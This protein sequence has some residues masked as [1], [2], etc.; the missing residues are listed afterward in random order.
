[1]STA[2]R[3][4]IIMV[5]VLA[6]A[7]L[8]LI[9]YSMNLPKAQVPVQI[10]ESTPAPAPA[11]VGYFVAAHPLPRGT[12]ARDEDFTTRSAS[13]SDGVPAGAILDTPDARIGLRGSLVRNFLDT[14]SPVTSRDILRPRERG[15]LASVLAP[16][17]RAISI[18]VDAASGV[19]GLIWPGDYVDVVLTEESTTAS[20]KQ[21]PDHQHGTLTETVA[22]NV[23]I[24]AIDQEIVQGGSA[25][26][27]S[28]GKV[29]RTVSL[30]LAPEQVK[31]VVVAVQLGKLSLAVRSAVDRQDTG[32]TDATIVIYARNSGTKYSVRRDDAGST[33]V[34]ST[35]DVLPAI[36]SSTPVD[37]AVSSRR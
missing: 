4:S 26:N 24:V 17:S 7:A 9:A 11:P 33:R 34:A 20:E 37:S 6:T 8:G 1:M 10:A 32:D 12:L 28:A 36:A 2:L 18:N 25:S 15:F 29:A 16:D 21:N 13:S 22:H 35:G 19:S 5:F 3:L 23:R 31:K 30:Q 27:A 14:G